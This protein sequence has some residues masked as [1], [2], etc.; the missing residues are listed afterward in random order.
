[1]LLHRYEIRDQRCDEIIE[2]GSL[3]SS[4]WLKGELRVSDRCIEFPVCEVQSL[5]HRNTSLFVKDFHAAWQCWTR[6]RKPDSQFHQGIGV[7]EFGA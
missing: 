1:M 2:L 3:M 7:F 6:D 5:G 4:R